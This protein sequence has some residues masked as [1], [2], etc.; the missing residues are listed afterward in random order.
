MQKLVAQNL[1]ANPLPAK[2]PTGRLKTK[3]S[4]QTQNIQFRVLDWEQDKV[5]SA[6]SAP[7]SSFDA[8]VATDCVY[9][10]ALVEPFVQTCVDLCGLREKDEQDE[11]CVCLVA[12]QL[13][14]DEVF[15]SWLST[16][17]TK[18]RVWRVKEADLLPGLTAA[19]GFVVHVGVLR[20]A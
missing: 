14:N 12:Q 18:F 19:D 9:N 17:M 10:Y 15:R 7:A 2:K 3:P 11:P 1:T 13:R 20:D 6:L 16:F 4:A 8:V 5:T